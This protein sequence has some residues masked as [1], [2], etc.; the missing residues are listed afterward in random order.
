[1]TDFAWSS[2]GAIAAAVDRGAAGAGEVIDQTLQR[3]AHRNPLL[4]ALPPSP[5]TV[6][7]RAPRPS[8]AGRSPVC[9]LRSRT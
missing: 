8:P 5:P 7:G 4:N 6:R 2:A 9:L 1:M 3:I